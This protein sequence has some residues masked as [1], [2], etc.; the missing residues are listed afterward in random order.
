MLETASRLETH[1]VIQRCSSTN[2][3]SKADDL[4]ENSKQKSLKK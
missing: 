2:S 3:K 1:K 4:T